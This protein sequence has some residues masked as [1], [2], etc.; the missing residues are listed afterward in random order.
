MYPWVP[1]GPFFEHEIDASGALAKSQ[2]LVAMIAAEEDE[3]VPA[4][5]T[6]A[7]KSGAHNLVFDRTIPDAGH[8]DI[9]ARSDFHEAM[10]DALAA[11]SA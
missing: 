6:D 4:K 11:V 1:I 10:R 5:R 3:I 8:N 2:V 7:L 9:Y